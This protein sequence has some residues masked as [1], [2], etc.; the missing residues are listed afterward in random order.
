[1]C[2]RCSQVYAIDNS[3][4][5][6]NPDNI[7]RYSFL[8]DD[9]LPINSPPGAPGGGS[10]GGGWTNNRWAIIATIGTCPYTHTHTHTHTHT[11][12]CVTARAPWLLTAWGGLAVHLP[13]SDIGYTG[14]CVLTCGGVIACATMQYYVA[15]QCAFVRDMQH[16]FVS[17]VL[18]SPC[19][20]QCCPCGHHC[21]YRGA[22]APAAREE[23]CGHARTATERH[24]AT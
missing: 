14:T 15:S 5:S 7:G 2:G 8:V 4:N 3:G 18:L 9:S 6:G 21:R 1:M 11:L 23:A 13:S 19:S 12:G 16:M 22:R 24:G 20:G 10:G 17:V